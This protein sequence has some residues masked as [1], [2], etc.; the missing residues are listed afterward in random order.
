MK[1]VNFGIDLGTTN[2]LIAKYDNGQIRL[3]RNLGYRLVYDLGGGTFDIALVEIKGGEMKVQDHVGNNFLGGVDF[4]RLI[5]ENLIVP[6]IVEETGVTDFAEQL[7]VKYGKYEKLYYL[8]LY[9]AEE[10]KKELTT[11]NVAEID[12]S[13][14]IDGRMFE[15]FFT[16]S[17]MQFNDLIA[18]K[19]EETIRMLHTIL[20]NNNLQTCNINEI[21]L[22]GGSTLIPYIRAKLQET[23][24]RVNTSADPITAIAV[25]AAFYA[26]GKYY[27]PVESVNENESI[28]GMALT[29]NCYPTCRISFICAFSMPADLRYKRWRKQ[30]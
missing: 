25:G 3:F 23:G 1:A 10:V 4:D 5:V 14:E 6:H 18:P 7:T 27:Q 13:A 16:I 12:F 30:L 21:V 15:F 19:V 8:L 26:A 24:I 11:R 17:V 29:P 9:H 28:A 20:D 2:S 22:V